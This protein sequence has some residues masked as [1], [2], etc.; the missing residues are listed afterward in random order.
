MKI[1]CDYD[2][3]EDLDEIVEEYKMYANEH[4]SIVNATLRYVTAP[5]DN[6]LK[7]L[8]N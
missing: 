7:E 2:K 4:Q 3:V 8:K 6:Q 1:V 5:A